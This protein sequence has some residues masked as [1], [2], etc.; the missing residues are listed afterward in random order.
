MKYKRFIDT[1]GGW[2]VYQQILRAADQVARKH[3]VSISNVATRWVLENSAVAGVIIGA[4]LGEAQHSADNANL[5]GFA[6]DAE[7]QEL[8]EAAFQASTP[9][10]GDCGDEYRK[11][12]FLTASGD[13]SHHLDEMPRAVEAEP[14]PGRKAHS[15]C[16]PE[17]SG[18]T[19]PAIV[20]PIKLVS[21][22]WSPA[23]PRPPERAGLL[24]TGD[25]GRKRHSF[26]IKSPLPYLP[27]AH[28]CPMS[29]GQEFTC[30]TPMMCLPYRV[31]MGGSSVKSNRPTHW[32]KSPA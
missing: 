21:G 27:S 24:P 25:A 2:S 23:P 31:P 7:D 28:R 12:P 19:L 17:A 5:F 20:A 1:A 10:P 4:R 26:S 9:L 18:K 15:G 32:L 3:Q 13:L 11:P 14:V 29:C 16:F 6:L 30:L 22:F 8:L